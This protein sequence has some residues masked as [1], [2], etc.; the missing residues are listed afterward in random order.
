MSSIRALDN[1]GTRGRPGRAYVLYVREWLQRVVLNTRMNRTLSISIVRFCALTQFT[2]VALLA[3]VYLPSRPFLVIRIATY[4]A[5]AFVLLSLTL[6]LYVG[7]LRHQHRR[8]ERVLGVANKLTIIRFALVVPLVL[9]VL[10]GRF[11]MACGTYV[12]CL[13][14]DVLDGIVA[15][16]SETRTDLGTIMDPLADI[17]STTG[18]FGALLVRDLM[19]AWVFAVLMTRYLSLFAGC[20][21]LFF[22]VGPLRIRATPV[23][24]IVGV[25][26]G[27]A[28]IMI[29]ILAVSGLQ[30]QEGIG[31][32]VFPALGM[33]FG[34]VIVSQLVIGV[35][36]IKRGALGARS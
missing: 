25:L 13:G 24:K 20:A 22:A 5:A 7:L 19:P 17:A 18:L 16:R 31:V 33:V 1:L 8:S 26:Q 9:L 2:V 27:A 30:W 12:V 11:I 21:I 10:D 15:R 29:L 36:Y 35:G 34:S 4:G 6:A 3:A 23:G 28:G 14:T 32:A